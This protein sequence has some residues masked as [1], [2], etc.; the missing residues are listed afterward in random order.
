MQKHARTVLSHCSCQ[1]Y[2]RLEEVLTIV[3][4]QAAPCMG[5]DIQDSVL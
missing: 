2:E 5:N 3:F 4:P 1:H